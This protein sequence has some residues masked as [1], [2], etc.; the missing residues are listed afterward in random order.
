MNQIKKISVLIG[1]LLSGCG[2][3]LAGKAE[4]D[5]VFKHT[6]VSHQAGGQRIAALLEKQFTIN[7]VNLVDA[8]QASVRVNVLYEHTSREVLSLDETGKVR[9][10]QL[11]LKTA[12]DIR[13]PAGRLLVK[14][15][16]IRL[17]RDFLFEINQVL[18]KANEEQQIYQEMRED[19]ARLILYRMQAVSSQD[20]DQSGSSDKSKNPAH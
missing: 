19:I 18:G 10:Y 9:E 7:G 15:A 4:L 5:P 17:T 1:L 11:I 20:S 13:D 3:Q 6:H 2:Y 12:V 8:G 14:S 16:E